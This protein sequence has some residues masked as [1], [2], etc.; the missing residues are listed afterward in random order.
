[1]ADFTHQEVLGGR[2]EWDDGEGNV[3]YVCDFHRV[4]TRSGVVWTNKL[5][6]ALISLQK[7]TRGSNVE[8]KPGKCH[9]CK[10]DR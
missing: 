10:E 8:L 4:A 2:E 3:Y 9:K 6:I 7:L 1:M 5:Y